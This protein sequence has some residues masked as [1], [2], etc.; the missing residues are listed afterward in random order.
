MTQNSRVNAPPLVMV[1]CAITGQWVPDDEII[2]L[3]GHRVCADGKLELLERLRSG[4]GIGLAPGSAPG[5]TD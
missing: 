5:S 4:Q 3:Q 2:T 1:Q